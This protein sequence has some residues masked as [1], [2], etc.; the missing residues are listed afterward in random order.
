MLFG[1]AIGLVFG[2]AM[3]KSKVY[4]PFI[5]QE[6]MKFNNFTML[7]MFLAATSAG[8]TS[9][10]LIRLLGHEPPSRG[11]SAL[12]LGLLKGYGGNIIGGLILGAGMMVSG[13]CPGTGT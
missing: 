7:K 1:S 12:G 5:I 4:V 6:Q 10:T 3:E 8:L 9:V 2:T 11:A 13:A